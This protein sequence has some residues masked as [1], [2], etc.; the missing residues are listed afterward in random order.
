MKTKMHST[1]RIGFR[2]NSLALFCLIMAALPALSSC[3]TQRFTQFSPGHLVFRSDEYI[4]CKL[5]RSETPEA[6]AKRF[7]NNRKKSWIIEDENEGTPFT[8]GETIVIPLKQG[9]KGGVTANGYQTVPVIG[10]NHFSEKC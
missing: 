7:L 4:I 2:A 8:K 5:K 10:Y 6:L 9:N 1:Y 3:V